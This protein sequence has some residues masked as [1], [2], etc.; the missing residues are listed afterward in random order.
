MYTLQG[1]A[2]RYTI[3][4]DG[5]VSSFYNLLTMHEYVFLKGN[6]WKLIYH[7]GER[8]EI[9]VYSANQ[10][11]E[12]QLIS[13][14]PDEETLVLTYDG[15]YGDGRILD[16]SLTLYLTMK[17]DCLSVT[18]SIISRDDA[19]IMEFQLTAASGIR[20]LSGDPEKDT[21]A[22]PVDLGR[23]IPRPALSD[24]SVYAGFR[25]YER[26]DE[27]HTDLDGLY[28]GSLSMQW[29]DLYNETEGLYVGAH[30]SS[31]QTICL[32]AERDVKTNILRMGV[33]QYPLMKKGKRWESEPVVY[34]PPPW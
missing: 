20:S 14:R 1:S 9:P 11:F 15:L 4:E 24:F 10:E 27:V 29:Y 31:H 5:N 21:I 16:V 30:N 2:L 23:R 33:I 26:R 13:P 7:E 19:E 25:K 3:D 8:M 34:A 6:L 12:A 17:P 28:P 18:S 22:W 32:H